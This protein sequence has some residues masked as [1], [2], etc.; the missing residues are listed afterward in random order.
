MRFVKCDVC[1]QVIDPKAP[2]MQFGVFDAIKSTD[3]GVS[4]IFVYHPFVGEEKAQVIELCEP[5][6]KDIFRDG[7]TLVDMARTLATEV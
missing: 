2:I 7:R 4:N 3:H 6:Y 1:G 5:C